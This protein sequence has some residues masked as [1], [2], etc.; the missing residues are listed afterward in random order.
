MIKTVTLT[1]GVN[2]VD[3]SDGQ[4][5]AY[6]AYPFAHIKVSSGSVIVSQT[7]DVAEGADGTSKTDSYVR[8]DLTG[9]KLYMVGSG[10]VEIH[11]SVTAVS[12]FAK[13]A[14]GGGGS[15][16]TEATGSN[17]L[18]NSDFKINQ[19][20]VSG[21]F[22]A[23]GEYF[24]DRWRLESG[25]VTVNDD[26]TL[27]LNGTICQPLE[28]SI[29]QNVTA[30]VSAGDASYDDNTK[31]FTVT[32]DNV[33]ISWAKL[34][35]GSTFTGFVPPDPSVEMIRCKRY[36]EIML[37]RSRSGSEKT[38]IN[39]WLIGLNFS[40]IKRI[41]PK[42]QMTSEKGTS[43]VLTD[44]EGNDSNI[45]FK[46]D[47]FRITKNGITGLH[48]SGSLNSYDSYSFYCHADAEIYSEEVD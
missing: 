40:V 23:V 17:L 34:E 24:V 39:E 18:I 9:N 25:T 4:P 31:I 1:D 32:G 35:T 2:A 38:G 21:E 11:T 22:S 5:M 36:Y 27:T 12:P 14:E 7:P 33:V 46:P 15:Y 13:L 10:A 42:I 3:I 30:T 20:E 41:T 45:S 48:C 8:I 47:D 16:V 44:C 28:N 43:N 37:V 29:G 6:I 26:K 19:R